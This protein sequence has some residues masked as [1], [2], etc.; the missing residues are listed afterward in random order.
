[1]IL[2]SYEYVK[3]LIE[4]T[5]TKTVLKVKAHIVK[6]LYQTGR[7]YSNNFKETMRIILDDFLGPWNY[8]AIPEIQY[9]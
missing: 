8:I 3:E 9:F 1:M 6:K 2:R 7:K 5:T 4:N